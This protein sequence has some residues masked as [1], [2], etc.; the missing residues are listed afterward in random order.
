MFQDERDHHFYPNLKENS[1]F[2]SFNEGIF[3]LN[4][5]GSIINSQMQKSSE[6][7]CSQMNCQPQQEDYHFILANINCERDNFK[8]NNGRKHEHATN[9]LEFD[10][11]SSKIT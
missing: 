10:A 5:E 4:A 11:T 2:L 8:R 9:I 1:L 6:N 3:K 7:G